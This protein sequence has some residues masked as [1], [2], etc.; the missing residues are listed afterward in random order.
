[1]FQAREVPGVKIFRFE[2]SLFF[3]NTEHFRTLLYKRT[4]N[5]RTVK[6]AQK[7]REAKLEKLKKKEVSL[8]ETV[9]VLNLSVSKKKSSFYDRCS[10][11][12]TVYV[13]M[14]KI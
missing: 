5:P 7:K 2:H 1:M 14:Q 9:H 6:I 4:A 10:V 13:N 8:K 12:V 11:V 3:V